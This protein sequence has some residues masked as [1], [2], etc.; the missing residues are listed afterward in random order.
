[1][2]TAA[3]HLM[4]KVACVHLAIELD[5]DPAAA[6]VKGEEVAAG[7]RDQEHDEHGM[8]AAVPLWQQ[9][10]SRNASLTLEPLSLDERLHRR[11]LHPAIDLA[12]Q[13]VGWC[14][15]SWPRQQGAQPTPGK[16]ACKHQSWC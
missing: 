11:R 7:K 4:A 12:V 3:E 13:L 10:Y 15:V 5:D 14:L 16:P 2:V 1:M 9:L 6:L 8:E